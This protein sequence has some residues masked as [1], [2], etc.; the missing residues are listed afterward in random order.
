[1]AATADAIAA[2]PKQAK[3]DWSASWSVSSVGPIAN[4]HGRDHKPNTSWC[5]GH[6]RTVLRAL[7]VR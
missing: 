1:M 3:I 6:T 4:T 2:I 7:G 5:T